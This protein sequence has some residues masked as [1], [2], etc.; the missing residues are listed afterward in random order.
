MMSH[1]DKGFWMARYDLLLLFSEG[2]GREQR[3]GDLPEGCNDSRL[4][5]KRLK[6]KVGLLQQVRA[7][8]VYLFIVKF[9]S[10]GC[11]RMCGP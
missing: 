3:D 4:H 11:V 10:Q 5:V 1:S 7:I 2:Y 9:L 8:G 6:N